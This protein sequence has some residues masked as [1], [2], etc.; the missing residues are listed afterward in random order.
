MKRRRNIIVFIAIVFVNFL[1]TKSQAQSSYSYFDVEYYSPQIIDMIRYD[2]ASINQN[3][4]R[5]DLSIPLINY[6]DKDFD[7][8]ISLQYNSAGFKPTSPEGYTGLNWT[9]MAGGM[10]YREVNGIA[11]D[12]VSVMLDPRTS[13]T[14]RGFLRSNK[15]YDAEKIFDNPTDFISIDYN[16]AGQGAT[17][18]Y[19]LISLNLFKGTN[20]EASSDIYHFNFGK[21]SGKFIINFDGSVTAASQNGGKY[22]V[23][24]SQYHSHDPSYGKTND[25]V[26]KIITD[27]GYTY[28]FGGSVQA[29][30]YMALSWDDDPKMENPKSLGPKEDT[31]SKA[32]QWNAVIN[33]KGYKN[34]NDHISAYHLFKVVAP[35]GRELKINYKGSSIDPEFHR[36]PWAML[37]NVKYCVDKKFY[38][39]YVMNISR[40]STAM[41]PSH[42]LYYTLSKIALIESIEVDNN[43]F[44][45][46]YSDKEEHIYDQT[47]NLYLN[48]FTRKCGVKLDSIVQKNRDTSKRIEATRL[49]YSYTY[50]RMF[51][52]SVI[53]NKQGRYNFSYNPQTYTELTT[54]NIDH[55]GFLGNKVSNPTW[56]FPKADVERFPDPEIEGGTYV[57][58]SQDI[59]YLDENREPTGENFKD[60]L[61][62]KVEFPTGGYVLYEYEPHYYS[63]Y[64]DRKK[65][66]QYNVGLHQVEPLASDPRKSKNKLAGGARIRSIKFFTELGL[67]KMSKYYQ[68]TKD[69]DDL[70]SSGILMHKHRY[71]F[72]HKI[73]PTSEGFKHLT[74]YSDIVDNV[75]S[76]SS[77]H[78]L[79]STVLE[80]ISPNKVFAEKDSSISIGISPNMDIREQELYISVSEKDKYSIWKLMGYEG[81]KNAKSTITIKNLT[82]TFEKVYFFEP[83]SEYLISPFDDFGEGM[84]KILLVAE[85]QANLSFKAEYRAGDVRQIDGQYK[86]TTFSDFWTYPSY[87]PVQK[88]YGNE[89]AIANIDDRI[90]TLN[91]KRQPSIFYP[92]L[93]LILSEEYYDIESN[94]KKTILYY[95]DKIE[96]STAILAYTPGNVMGNVGVGTRFGTFGYINKHSFYSM[97]PTEKR[98]VDFIEGESFEIDE[99]YAYNNLGYLRDEW[100]WDSAGNKKGITYSYLSDNLNTD[101]LLMNKY[102]ILSPLTDILKHTNDRVTSVQKNSFSLVENLNGD[103][104]MPIQIKTMIG[105]S[106]EDLVVDSEIL[107]SDRYGNPIHMKNKNNKETIILW[108]HGGRYPIVNIEN[109]S[110]QQ[111]ENALGKE[112][113]SISSAIE[114]DYT[115]I[116][117]LKSKLPKATITI[118]EFEPSIGLKSRTSPNGTTTYYEYDTLGRLREIYYIEDGEKCILELNKYHLTNEN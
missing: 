40:S 61:L 85:P 103:I 15:K 101:N 50:K 80:Y 74:A 84:Y 68:Y 35:N 108:G 104:R 62:N 75:F 102:N 52:S 113:S 111:V 38:H 2:N 114:P 51:L 86:K 87:G 109:A 79:Y 19:N 115:V 26:I 58:D 81:N 99:R 44:N 72:I 41:S 43:I 21:H 110:Y 71:A 23:D 100:T 53:N 77:D 67:P 24:I 6:Q 89:N 66:N 59:V 31:S 28:H 22:I 73:K 13:H 82:S 92:D 27:D 116:R 64:L 55:W 10:I 83:K 76:S 88:V 25:S 48:D 1:I 95:Y 9:L 47:S 56:M 12:C 96:Y 5:I 42:I 70:T 14:F 3:S 105:R 33:G 16:V 39:N 90:F 93:G 98:T 49:E 17:P 112:L 7:I 107:R 97:F 60:A 91:Y 78:V 11:D 57:F 30:E 94:I 63:R 37:S 34:R 32:P 46:H 8:P 69:K 106:L 36:N 118:S 117:D 65:N 18:I 29:M 4:G 54:K 20:I 45:F